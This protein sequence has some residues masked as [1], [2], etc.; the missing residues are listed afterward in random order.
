M[1]PP[2]VHTSGLQDFVHTPSGYFFKTESFFPGV[3][4]RF[5][6]HINGV[7]SSNKVNRDSSFRKRFLKCFF[8]IQTPAYRLRVDERKGFS[9]RRCRTSTSYTTRT[10]ALITGSR[11]ELSMLCKG[12]YRIQFLFHLFS[13][14]MSGKGLKYGTD[15]WTRISVSFRTGKKISVFKKHPVAWNWPE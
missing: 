8:L 12:K 2:P 1:R 6:P 14:F 7:L 3:F 9:I 15:V 10:G 4:L 5:T 13:I 11:L